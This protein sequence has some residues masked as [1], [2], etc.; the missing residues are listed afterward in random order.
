MDFEDFWKTGY[1]VCRFSGGIRLNGGG[2]TLGT[3]VHL[4]VKSALE[5]IYPGTF[6]TFVCILGYTFSRYFSST[7]VFLRVFTAWKSMYPGTFRTFVHSTEI[8]VA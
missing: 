3:L 4:G 5:K 2:A 8:D 7:L 1:P 6:G